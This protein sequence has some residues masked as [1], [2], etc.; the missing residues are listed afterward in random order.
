MKSFTAFSSQR[1]KT[2]HV[3]RFFFQLRLEYF[4]A[5]AVAVIVILIVVLIVVAVLLIRLCKSRLGGGSSSIHSDKITSINGSMTALQS[6][7]HGATVVGK[8]SQFFSF[9]LFWKKKSTFGNFN[10]CLFLGNGKVAPIP[11]KMP[12]HIQMGTGFRMPS[13]QPQQPQ[14]PDLLTEAAHNLSRNS[15]NTTMTS[16]GK[17]D[18][19]ATSSNAS[20][21]S[22]KM[23]ME[24]IIED[25]HGR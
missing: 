17:G 13:S 25:Y 14:K 19:T 15:V 24:N 7:Y 3:T 5:V 23:A 10:I 2:L 22:Y 4:I 12:K 9:F 6:P 8:M 1:I 11:S 20:H 21:G 16:T 18:S